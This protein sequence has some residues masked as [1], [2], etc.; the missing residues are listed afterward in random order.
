[1]RLEECNIKCADIPGDTNYMVFGTYG[2]DVL[3][4]RYRS[5]MDGLLD[6]FTD[7]K[8]LYGIPEYTE[9]V[10]HGYQRKAE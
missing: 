6:K 5:D 2:W 4:D 8:Y 1:M 3:K 7:I 9:E 10:L